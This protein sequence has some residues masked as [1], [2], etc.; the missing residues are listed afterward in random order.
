MLVFSFLSAFHCAVALA[1]LMEHSSL[2]DRLGAIREGA[3]I[4]GTGTKRWENGMITTSY[5]LRGDV[6]YSGYTCRGV[7]L[8]SEFNSQQLLI[9]I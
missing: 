3:S 8:K 1:I 5:L 6:G 7:N 2:F 4:K 9:S